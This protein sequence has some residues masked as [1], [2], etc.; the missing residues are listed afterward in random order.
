MGL[1]VDGAKNILTW[2]LR[3]SDRHGVENL[4][5]GNNTITIICEN[6]ESTNTSAQITVECKLPFQLNVIHSGGENQFKIAKGRHTVFTGS[7]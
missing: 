1:R 5:L 3:R 7:N 2:K 6:R 4:K